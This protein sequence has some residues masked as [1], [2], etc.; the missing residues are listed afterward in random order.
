M[1][2]MH[3]AVQSTST[4]PFLARAPLPAHVAGVLPRGVRICTSNVCR[5]LAVGVED[6]SASSVSV[7]CVCILG[8]HVPAR[9]CVLSVL[10]LHYVWCGACKGKCVCAHSH[11]RIGVCAWLPVSICVWTLM[12]LCAHRHH[13]SPAAP[14][15]FRFV[16]RHVECTF[17]RV[18]GCVMPPHVVRR[19]ISGG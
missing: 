19:C 3:R 16:S 8:P 13:M 17:G 7:A 15:L 9:V 5:A 1:G 18:C 14:C 11:V 12:Y 4:G 2:A 6:R 10:S